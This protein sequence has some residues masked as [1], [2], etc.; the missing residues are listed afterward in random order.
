M[1]VTKVPYDKQTPGLSENGTYQKMPIQNV[2]LRTVINFLKDCPQ[3]N[4]FV[5][6]SPSL[7]YGDQRQTNQLLRTAA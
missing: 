3:I 2:K 4:I 1:N 6:Y 7:K 5:R